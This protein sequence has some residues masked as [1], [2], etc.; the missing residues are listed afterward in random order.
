MTAEER[1]MK[2]LILA[3]QLKVAWMDY[4]ENAEDNDGD[5]EMSRR[6]LAAINHAY[7]LAADAERETRKAVSQ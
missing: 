3:E 6:M 5:R 4:L 7:E 2:Y 1:Q